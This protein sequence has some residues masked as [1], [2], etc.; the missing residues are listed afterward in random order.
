MKAFVFV[1]AMIAV[2][3]CESAAPG[4]SDE[5]SVA[6]S[7]TTQALPAEHGSLALSLGERLGGLF[8]TLGSTEACQQ[9]LET[10]CVGVLEAVAGVEES[11]TIDAVNSGQLDV[12]V[13]SVTVTSDCG[14]RLD[15]TSGFVVNAGL[16]VPVDVSFTGREVSV[17]EGRFAIVSDEGPTSEL[18]TDAIILRA[19]VI[20]ETP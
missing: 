7:S 10:E 18:G 5:C 17:C 12:T 8:C 19:T 2:A 1:V 16:S 15:D 6:P 4:P 14:W 13:E 11:V 9:Q 20:A 3:G